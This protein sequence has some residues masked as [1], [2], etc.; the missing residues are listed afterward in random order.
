[1]EQT[2]EQQLKEKYGT[3]YTLSVKDSN[4]KTITVFLRKLDRTAYSST[5]AII[6]KDALRGIESLLKTLWIGGDDVNLII[7]DFE[8]LR[9]AEVTL[10]EMIQAKQGILKKN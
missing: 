9:S 5:S 10:I 1:M 4:E 8:A 3:V 6:Q 7:D 2:T